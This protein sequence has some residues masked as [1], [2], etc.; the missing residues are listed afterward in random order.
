MTGHGLAATVW[1]REL[2]E[3]AQRRRALVIKLIFPLVVGLP[4]LF[5]RA[6]SVYAAMALTMLATMIGAVGSGAVL[7]RERLTGLNVRYRLLPRRPAALLCERLAVSAAI[8]LMQLSPILILLA[9][10]HP[11]RWPYWPALLIGTAAVLAMTNV[12]GAW[13]STLTTSPGEVMLVVLLPVLPALFLSG[14]FTTPASPAWRAIADVLPFTYLHDALL[15]ALF[16]AP[17][18]S[19]LMDLGGATVFVLVAGL[20]AMLLARHVLETD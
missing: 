8:D 4:L 2:L 17:R 15:G 3:F 16:A 10:R 6:P 18:L 19:A 1:Q 7:T 20:C 13:A 9:I 5:S 11:S 14:V 12:L